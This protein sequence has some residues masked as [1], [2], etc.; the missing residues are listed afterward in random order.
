LTRHE[1]G[2][3]RF[4]AGVYRAENRFIAVNRPAAENDPATMTAAQARKLFRDVSFQLHQERG[5]AGDR[6]Q[7][8]IWRVFVTLML[9][10]LV[11]EGILILPPKTLATE[12]REPIRPRPPAEVAA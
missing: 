4:D 5:R 1:A 10:F 12:Q 3:P 6:L 7:G 8:E 2:N 9:M 11:L